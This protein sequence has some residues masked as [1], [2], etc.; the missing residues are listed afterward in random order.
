MQPLPATVV[1]VKL[2]PRPCPTRPSAPEEADIQSRQLPPLST[3]PSG[4]VPD[5]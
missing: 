2:P 1:Q 4:T 3:V 5:Q